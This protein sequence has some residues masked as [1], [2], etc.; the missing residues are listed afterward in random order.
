MDE[1]PRLSDLRSFLVWILATKFHY[2]IIL[3]IIVGIFATLIIN[4]LDYAVRALIYI[5]PG[6]LAAIFV[7]NLYR[8]GEKY[9]ETLNLMQPH[10]KF[11]QILFVVLFAL[12]LLALYFSPPGPGIIL[13]YSPCCSVAFSCRSSQIPSNRRSSCLKSAV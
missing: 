12:S 10:R 13:S 5:V 1:Q 6:L 7:W 2:L 11:F 4:R 8:N 9:P 3:G